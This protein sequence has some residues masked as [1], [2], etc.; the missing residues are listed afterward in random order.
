MS[1]M[2]AFVPNIGSQQNQLIRIHT[3]KSN[4]PLGES[5]PGCIAQSETCLVA[6]MCLTAD[7]GV[8][9]SILPR[10]RH[11][12]ISTFI[13]PSADSRRVISYKRKFVHEVL[14]NCLVRF[15]QKKVDR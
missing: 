11:E 8:A 13:L 14:V 7:P 5:S 3:C 15:A 6:N 12:I 4:H 1:T 2:F 9:S 10:W